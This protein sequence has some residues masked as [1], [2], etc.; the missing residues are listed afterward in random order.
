RHHARGWRGGRGRRWLITQVEGGDGRRRRVA[1]IEVRGC[2]SG[3]RGLGRG[4]RG[5][6]RRIALRKIKGHRRGHRLVL[7][8]EVQ[9][10]FIGGWGR[11]R[12]G[13]AVED[14]L[15]VLELELF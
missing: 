3:F 7:A 9:E 5:G 14:D 2:G 13:D 15:A 4:G 11:A 8:A 10:G 6:Y 1:Q 12:N